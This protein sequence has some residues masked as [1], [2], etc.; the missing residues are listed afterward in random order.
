MAIVHIERD[1][2]KLFDKLTVKQRNVLMLMQM[3]W[4]TASVS[5]LHNREVPT[6]TVQELMDAVKKVE[7]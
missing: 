7:A 5:E 2:E 1:V 3:G 4:L 6:I